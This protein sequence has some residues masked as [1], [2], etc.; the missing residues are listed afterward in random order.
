MALCGPGCCHIYSDLRCPA[1]LLLPATGR[2]TSHMLFVQMLSA[3]QHQVACRKPADAL[4]S[5]V[6][7]GCM[8][9][10]YHQ[11]LARQRCSLAAADEA[12][13]K[14]TF[15]RSLWSS[16][17]PEVGCVLAACT[18]GSS[19]NAPSGRSPLL[20]EGSGA[21]SSWQTAAQSPL[22]L[23]GWPLPMMNDSPMA[24]CPARPARP[25]I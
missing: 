11:V 9:A 25:T 3:V 14:K 15:S 24:A 1:S 2:C 5:G 7:A 12:L 4:C 17:T 21:S 20:R 23:P 18:P 16:I 10:A 8:L 6:T 13:P 22:A 19:A